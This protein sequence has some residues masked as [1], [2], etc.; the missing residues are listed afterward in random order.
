MAEVR[1]LAEVAK[2]IPVIAAWYQAEWSDWFD[3]TPIVEIEADLVSV[4][5]RVKL[6][7]GLVV[8]DSSAQL[9]GICALRDDPFDPY[10]HAGPWLRGLYVHGPWRG[11]GFAGELI[12]AAEQEAARLGI[13]RL[14][15][16]TG[17]AVGVF[18]RAGWLGFDEV[19]HQQQVLT[20]FAK[21]IGEPHRLP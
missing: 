11:N 17:T 6:P 7:L 12:H 14:F 19:R 8:F 20:I 16:A 5:N 2:T 1:L 9:A 15:A 21:R 13:T 10:P 18:E 3:A 4:A